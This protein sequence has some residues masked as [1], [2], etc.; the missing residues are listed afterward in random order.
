[1]GLVLTLFF[2]FVFSSSLC[3]SSSP[4]THSS[5]HICCIHV[6]WPNP[7]VEIVAG[8]LPWQLQFCFLHLLRKWTVNDGNWLF[9]VLFLREMVTVEDVEELN[10]KLL[11][12][13][14]KL[15]EVWFVCHFFSLPNIPFYFIMIIR[16][17]SN[18]DNCVCVC[19]CVCLS[20]LVNLLLDCFLQE[21]LKELSSYL[22]AVGG[23]S[24]CPLLD[25]QT[26]LLQP[27]DRIPCK[28]WKK[29][30]SRKTIRPKCD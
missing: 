6:S 11:S 14:A 20:V 4:K 13:R 3:L 2:F 15:R 21:G 9:S 23:V 25:H 30:Q 17:C 29:I 5:S 19:V 8:S 28:L 12:E 10:G 18:L 16:M 27:S 7:E 22:D 26:G 1:M 24:L